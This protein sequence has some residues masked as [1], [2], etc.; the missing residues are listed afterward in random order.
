[1]PLKIEGIVESLPT[2]GAEI[3]LDVAVTFHVTIEKSLKTKRLAAQSTLESTGVLLAPGG[4]K[5]LY[6][7]LD[8]DVRGERILDTVA[9]VD[10][11]DW[12]VRGDSQLK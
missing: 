4:R 9:T 3:S 10:H 8:R 12:Q 11:L 2:K 6:L 5:L 7:G 1:M